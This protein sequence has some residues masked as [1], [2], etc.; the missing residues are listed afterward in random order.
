[1]KK[2]VHAT[3]KP[4]DQNKEARMDN[5]TFAYNVTKLTL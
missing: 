1:M 4:G 3:N 5:K 2:D